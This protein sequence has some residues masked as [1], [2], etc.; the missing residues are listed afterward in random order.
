MFS[1]KYRKLYNVQTSF[2]IE[3]QEEKNKKQKNY[4]N[5]CKQ[6]ITHCERVDQSEINC[7]LIRFNFDHIKTSTQSI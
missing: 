1:S 6:Q 3:T 7:E 2:N 5:V 4:L